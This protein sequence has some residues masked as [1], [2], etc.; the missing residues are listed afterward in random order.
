MNKIHGFTL[1]ATGMLALSAC[2]SA[3]SPDTVS[4]DVAAAQ[5]KAA[6]NDGQAHQEA[7]QDMSKAQAATENKAVDQNNAEAKAAYDV[8]V[9]RADGAHQVALEKCKALSG[10]L[11]SQCKSRADADYDAAK[12]NAKAAETAR[13][14]PN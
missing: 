5:H 1:F 13:Q 3:K 4:N 8:A 2:N 14:Q 10:D 11:Q 6:Q 7:T 12:A 9:T